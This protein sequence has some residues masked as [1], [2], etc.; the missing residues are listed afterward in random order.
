LAPQEGE[1]VTRGELYQAA[2]RLAEAAI[3]NVDPKVLDDLEAHSKANWS[4]SAE[5]MIY[6]GLEHAFGVGE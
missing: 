3:A 1:Q 5:G 2:Q 4:T 6:L